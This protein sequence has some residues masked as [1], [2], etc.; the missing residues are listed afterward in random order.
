MDPGLADGEFVCLSQFSGCRQIAL[1]KQ[2][3]H[4]GRSNLRHPKL[5]V[6]STH[7]LFGLIQNSGCA[8]HISLGKLQ[9]G[10][11]HPTRSERDD[12]FRL[13]RQFDALLPVLL[14]GIQVVP[15][16]VYSG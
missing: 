13:P 6:M 4:L 16:V 7:E 9:V 11:K 1:V 5:E 12:T 15:L 8:R 10:E 2:R 14:G 3:K